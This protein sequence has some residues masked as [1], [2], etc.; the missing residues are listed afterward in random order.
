[1]TLP[2]NQEHARFSQIY[3]VLQILFPSHFLA[4]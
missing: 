2:L 3:S 1:L 4:D